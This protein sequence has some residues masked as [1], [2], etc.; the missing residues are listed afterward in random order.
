[1]IDKNIKAKPISKILTSSII[2]TPL[3]NMIAI[4]DEQALYFL[5]FEDHYTIKD[6]IKCLKIKTTSTIITGVT[7]PINSIKNELQ[8]Y[9]Q[10]TLK[11]FKTPVC[12]YGTLFE[13]MTWQGLMTIPYAQT[14]S[15]KEL[16]A[17]LNNTKAYRA[18]GNANGKNP[19]IIMIP[20]HRVINANGQFG[21]YNAGIS[22]KKWLL[23]HESAMFNYQSDLGN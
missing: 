20:C 12:L 14:R 17:F 2:N 4:G 7:V 22:R 8:E 21:G 23:Q 1:M 16:A 15:Y 13:K 10:G 18:V 19:I 9:F 11:A 5:Q 6:D 3:G